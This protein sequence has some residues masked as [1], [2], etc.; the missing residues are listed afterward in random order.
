MTVG[1][2]I[3]Q[4]REE[5]GISQEELAIK[6]GLKGKS[7]VCKIEKA[8]DN[9][10]TRSIKKYANALNVPPSKLM[11]WDFEPEKKYIESGSALFN[12]EEIK[13][14]Y[15]ELE[16]SSMESIE[17]EQQRLG[18]AGFALKVALHRMTKQELQNLYDVAKIMIPHAFE[19]KEV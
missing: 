13:E 15:E 5:L 9:I 11:G 1:E 14:Y 6:I 3:K 19:D 2:R 12:D 4:I 18:T 16:K 8:G 17:F 10:S 7:S